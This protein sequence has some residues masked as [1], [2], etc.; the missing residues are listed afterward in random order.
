MKTAISKIY[1]LRITISKLLNPMN[2]TIKQQHEWRYILLLGIA[3]SAI[4]V[5]L[6]NFLLISD[7]L[8]YDFYSEQLSIEQIDKLLAQQKEWAWLSYVFVG[9][10]YLLK[11]TLVAGCIYTGFFFINSN[12]PKIAFKEIITIVAK[13]DLIFFIPILL[14]ILWFT[15]VEER[16]TIKDIQ[17]FYPLSLVNIYDVAS[18][19]NWLLYPLQTFNIFEILFWFA[20]AYELKNYLK[21]DFTASFKFVLSTYGSGLFVWVI[22]VVFLIVNNS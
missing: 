2:L 1:W 17:Q 18:L 5:F 13:T 16:F 20:L 14:K 19:E 6:N 11:I 8:M 15:F 4:M 22:F 7:N 3:F 9:V 10:L 21:E 12:G